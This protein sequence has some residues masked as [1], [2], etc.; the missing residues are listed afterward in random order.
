MTAEKALQYLFVG[1]AQCGGTYIKHDEFDIFFTVKIG[2]EMDK[3]E[4]LRRFRDLLMSKFM[5]TLKI[6]K[7][8]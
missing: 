3:P 7:V 2:S 4:V 1:A 6:K 5:L 8:A